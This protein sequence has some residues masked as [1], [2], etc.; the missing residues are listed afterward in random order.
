MSYHYTACKRSLECLLG[1]G[2]LGNFKSSTASLRQSSSGSS[3]L[4]SSGMK[5]GV[6]FTDGDWCPPYG[7]ALKRDISFE[8]FTRPAM[9]NSNT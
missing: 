2:A 3:Q 8:E 4:P 5:L 9:V 7:A 6:K 1:W